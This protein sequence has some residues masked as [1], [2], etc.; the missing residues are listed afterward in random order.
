MAGN[1]SFCS[2][3]ISCLYVQ[4]TARLLDPIVF[5]LELFAQLEGKAIREVVNKSFNIKCMSTY[6]HECDE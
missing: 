4:L 6:A 3:V 5:S 1:S 2:C